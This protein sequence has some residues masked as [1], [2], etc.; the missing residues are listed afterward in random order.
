MEGA[1]WTPCLVSVPYKYNR[2][3]L[4]HVRGFATQLF[5]EMHMEYKQEMYKLL[6]DSF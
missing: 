2:S 4:E 3:T 1:T 5:D 6:F